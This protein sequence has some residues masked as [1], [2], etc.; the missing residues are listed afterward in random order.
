M[1]CHRSTEAR[2]V[3][4]E[5]GGVITTDEYLA[6]IR[7]NTAYSQVVSGHAGFS[8]YF[9]MFLSATRQILFVS[10]EF[11]SEQSPS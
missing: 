3:L 6:Q 10:L 8:K 5:E 7:C 4:L 11:Q 1:Y 9:K 2:A